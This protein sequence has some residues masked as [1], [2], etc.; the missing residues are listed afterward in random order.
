MRAI[1]R[2]LL[3]AAIAVAA[4]TPTA[5]EAR[6]RGDH[7]HRGGHSRHHRGDFW[8][9]LNIHLFGGYRRPYD[10]RPYYGPYRTAVYPAYR[11]VVYAEAPY[12]EIDTDVKPTDCTVYLDGVAVGKARE[13]DGWPTK[14]RTTPGRHELVFREPG[15]RPLRVTVDLLAYHNV[16]IREH[17]VP[18][19]DDLGGYGVSEPYEVAPA[20]ESL[21]RESR[22]VRSAIVLAIEPEDAKVYV[23]GVL[24][25]DGGGAL[26]R[27]VLP[28]AAGEHRVEVVKP[29]YR[30][31][32]A[33]LTLGERQRQEL[34]V[35]LER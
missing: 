24:V 19:P 6:G 12:G 7:H 17:L 16:Q 18:G 11:P 29:G 15:Y 13:F 30:P 20:G 9:A 2:T 14:L 21:P 4:L 31:F 5:V 28:L 25:R 34:S 32:T 10:Y 1:P 3:A 8:G 35:R 22:D 27:L 23:D 26:G 33:V